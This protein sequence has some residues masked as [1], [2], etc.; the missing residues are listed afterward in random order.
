MKVLILG[1]ARHGKDTV[2]EL[3]T[4]MFGLKSISS[5]MFACERFIFPEMQNRY[6]DLAACFEDRVNHRQFWFD[7]ICGFN[8]HDKL[9]LTKEILATSDVYIG[10]RCA[11][12]FAAAL[13][14]KLFDKILWVDASARHGRDLTMKIVFDADNMIQID[15]NVLGLDFLRVQVALLFGK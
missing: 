11:D 12:E 13:D 7:A 2:A 8:K 4:E 1:H 9:A 3:L 5:S 10:M 14:E 6:A 15:N